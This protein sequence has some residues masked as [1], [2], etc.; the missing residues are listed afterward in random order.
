MANDTYKRALADGDGNLSLA[1]R[2]AA[3][4]CAGMTATALTHPIDTVRL[5][6]ALPSHPYNVSMYARASACQ[7]S[8]HPYLVVAGAP[9]V[10]VVSGHGGVSVYDD[11]AL[12]PLTSAHPLSP[13]PSP[14]RE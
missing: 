8:S 3:G 1:A 14:R 5:R 4:A 12:T 13:S 2:L 10:V 6:L 9:I 11:D 7:L